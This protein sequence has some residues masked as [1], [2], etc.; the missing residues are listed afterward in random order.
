MG[1]IKKFESYNESLK[2]S[3]IYMDPNDTNDAFLVERDRILRLVFDE[4]DTLLDVV[5]SDMT[6]NDFIGIDFDPEFDQ[7]VRE[8]I[9]NSSKYH[10][11]FTLN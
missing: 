8:I 5:E 11:H 4:G 9:E 1:Y 3:K 6:H 10:S 7:E 2:E